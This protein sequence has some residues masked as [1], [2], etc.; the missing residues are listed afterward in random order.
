MKKVKTILFYIAFVLLIW[1]ILSQL[2]QAIICPQLTQMEVFLHTPKSM[3]LDF[4]R[5]R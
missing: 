4:I 2:I 3:V 5:C 1:A